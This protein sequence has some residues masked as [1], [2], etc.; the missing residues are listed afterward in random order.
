MSQKGNRKILFFMQTVNIS[1]T[2]NVGIQFELAGLG[3]RIVA[4][5]IDGAILI[6]YMIGAALLMDYLGLDSTWMFIT[7]AMVPFFYHLICEVFFNGQSIG[8]KQM[9]IRVVRLDGNPASLGAYLMRWMLRLIEVNVLMGAPAI[10]SIALTENGQ[11]LGDMAAGTTVVKLSGEMKATS[12]SIVQRMDESY[13]PVFPQVIQ[14]SAK[15]VHLIEQV[16][17]AYR[18]NAVSKP[19][20]KVTEKVKEMLKI[21]SDLP[22]VKL[23]HLLLKDYN[24]LTSR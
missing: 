20:I 22:P 21:E 4:S 9:K 1:T 14:L 16:L 18:T 10:V 3:D 19:V 8:K 13:S 11:R 17:D 15:D 23:L 7:L 5:I 6:S 12:H 2:Q 24:Y